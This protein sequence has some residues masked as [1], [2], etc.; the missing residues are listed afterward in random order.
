MTPLFPR[1]PSNALWAM[2]SLASAIVSCPSLLT[3]GT[4]NFIGALKACMGMVGAANIRELQQ[5][6]LIYAP[7]IKAEGKSFQAA[8]KS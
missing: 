6:S 4:M 8:Q 3:D 7:D 5:A 1:A 2:A